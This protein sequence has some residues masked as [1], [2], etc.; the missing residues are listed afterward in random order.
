MTES[1]RLNNLA[2]LATPPE[3]ARTKPPEIHQV[4]PA[5]GTAQRFTDTSSL[6]P[7]DM[8]Q[9]L[10][11]Y[12]IG[13]TIKKKG[14]QSLYC[15]DHC[16]F[17]PDHADGQASIIASPTGP[18]IYQCFHATCKDKRW[19][20]AKARISGDKKLAEFCAGYNPDWT[21]PKN[22][23][24][25]AMAAI[26]VRAE[27]GIV[28]SEKVLPPEKVDP[29]EFYE[30]R[31]KRPVFVPTYLVNYL[32][33]YL[34]PIVHTSGVFWRF[35]NGLWKPFAE[36]IV[37]QIILQA[38]K[39]RWQ[40]DFQ[41]SAIKGLKAMINQEEDQWP[42]ETLLIPCAN[43]MLDIN[44]MELRDHDPKYG[45]RYQLPVSYHEKAWSQRWWDFLLEIFPDDENYA[46]RG[47]L[48][49]FFGYCLLRDCRY[50]VALFMYGTGANG[51]S[52]IL[53]VLQAMLGRENCSSMSLEDLCERFKPQFL[54]NKLVNLATETNSRNPMGTEMLKKLISGDEIT[55]E[56]KYGDQFQ[57]RPYAKF[58][59]ALNDPP[60]IPDKSYGFGRRIIVLNCDRRFLPEE[61]SAKAKEIGGKL[62]D[63]LIEELD[64][65]FSWA[66]DG[67]RQLLK[68]NGFKIPEEVRKDTDDMMETLNPL[69]IFVNEM[70]EVHD[71]AEVGTVELWECYA[72]WCAAGKNR[73]L[74]RNRFLDQITA[75]FVRVKKA[76]IGEPRRRGFKGIGL[77]HNSQLWTQERQT[78][79][80]RREEN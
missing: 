79:F 26:S 67:L 47:I 68:N 21:P 71:A 75:T 73:P 72:E 5:V 74:G 19:K 78:R 22:E 50:Q 55:C 42:K 76:E 7:I 2:A 54:Q 70:C 58:I 10:N 1:K 63:Y 23:G 30:K 69:L 64:G 11:H 48:Q 17:N 46:K 80:K 25:G 32:A 15:L 27:T 45:N 18:L 49:Q 14:E 8:E 13:Y 38:M 3:P 35:S 41:S 52:T 39:D 77:T 6:G 44:T 20:D 66:L 12:G 62:S 28:G 34:S 43:G 51:K 16:L 56:R 4:H 60:V 40:A 33:T 31:G 53:D 65:V 36:T 57:F 29:V 9:Y 24:T 61:I 37:S 59:A